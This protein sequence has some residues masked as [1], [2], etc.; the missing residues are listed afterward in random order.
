M[1]TASLAN[2]AYV[3]LETFKR[4]GQGIKTPVWCAPLDGKIVIF[5]ERESFKTKRLQRNPE[6]R[7]AACNLTG[8]LRGEALAGTCEIVAD[9]EEESRAYRALREKYGWQMRVLDVLS[10]A[11]GRIYGRAVLS[12]TLTPLRG[13]GGL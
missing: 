9:P 3:S 13:S 1:T 10:A 2:E 11:S 7:I 12:V 4:D 8:K 6:V 5:T